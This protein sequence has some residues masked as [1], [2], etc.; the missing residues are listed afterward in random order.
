MP[1]INNFVAYK[2]EALQFQC[3]PAAGTSPNITG[4]T[5]QFNIRAEAR[6]GTPVL[7][8]LTTSNGITVTDALNGLYTVTITSAQNLALGAGTYVFDVWRTDPGSESELA[9][10]K[11][12]ILP[13]AKW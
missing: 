7:L 8:S 10:G 6:P 12:Q 1:T 3:A 2:G 13:T 5:L 4:F 9:V 11:I